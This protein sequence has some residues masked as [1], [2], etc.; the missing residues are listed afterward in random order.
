MHRPQKKKENSKMYNNTKRSWILAR[1]IPLWHFG[2]IKEQKR[3][4]SSKS[5]KEG[6]AVF[7]YS[8]IHDP[9]NRSDSLER[10]SDLI[11]A[12]KEKKIDAVFI[13][14]I[15]HLSENID[16]A[17]QFVDQMNDYGVVVYDIDGNTY[18][19][20]WVCKQRGKYFKP[21]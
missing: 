21:R 16:K 18:S 8:G 11:D 12:A 19:Y 13:F 17:F 14:S 3:L 9:I 20:D 7:G 5:R 1:E 15:R 6:F 10:I 4:L 2:T